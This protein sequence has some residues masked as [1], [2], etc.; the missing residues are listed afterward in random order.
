MLTHSREHGNVTN[1]SWAP[2][3]SSIYYDRT[4]AMPQGIYNVPVLGGDEHRVFANAFRPEV[5]PD[6]SLLA[7]KIEFRP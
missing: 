3:G 7:G 6:G 1:V 5:L 4:A 2:D